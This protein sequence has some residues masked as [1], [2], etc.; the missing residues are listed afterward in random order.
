M[1]GTPLF[2]RSE[3]HQCSSHDVTGY[4]IP[5]KLG[6]GYGFFVLDV[7]ERLFIEPVRQTKTYASID[8]ALSAGHHFLLD[9]EAELM[10]DERKA[11]EREHL[12]AMWRL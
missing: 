5:T 11:E 10:E 4:I 1:Q 7:M 8:A 2:D 12:E 3:V 9:C 6:Q